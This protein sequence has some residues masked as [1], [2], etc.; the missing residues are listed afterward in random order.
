MTINEAAALLKEMTGSRAF[1]ND[2]MHYRYENALQSFLGIIN[3]PHGTLDRISGYA[4]DSIC[5]YTEKNSE[6]WRVFDNTGNEIVI[7]VI[8]EIE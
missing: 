8:G 7:D 3:R 5:S 2:F 4:I 6:N 1:C